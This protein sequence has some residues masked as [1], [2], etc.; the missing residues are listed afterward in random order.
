MAGNPQ[1]AARRAAHAAEQA[2]AAAARA[3]SLAA[4]AGNVEPL[5]VVQ[6]G[7]NAPA[8]PHAAEAR[9]PPPTQRYG[10]EGAP[11]RTHF[12]RRE[13]D[14]YAELT[15]Q[16]SPGIT[17]RIL[18]TRPSWCA[19]WIEDLELDS[20][21]ITELFEHLRAEH[22]GQVY[23]VQVI[24]R[25]NRILYKARVP[26]AGP[27]RRDGRKITREQWD[28]TDDAAAASSQQR[29]TGPRETNGASP[30]AIDPM[31]LVRMFLEMQATSSG[32]ITEAIREM[33][34]M[35]TKQT[36]GLVAAVMTQ[37]SQEAGSRTLG[38]QL[39]EVAAVAAQVDD[40]RAHFVASAPQQAAQPEAVDPIRAATVEIF[41]TAIQ[42]EMGRGKRQQTPQG[43]QPRPQRPQ[44]QAQP[45][46]QQAAQ[47]RPT[48][49]AAPRRAPNVEPL[50]PQK[51]SV[52]A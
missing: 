18:R 43:A 14:D 50:N 8:R 22:G 15:A 34:R 25:D 21:D 30:S 1:K 19:G 49:G 9:Q 41:K 6:P 7:P 33:Q 37:R 26:I 4:Q 42:N 13:A 17:C 16:L 36:E 48:N 23:S 46:P 11:A 52:T 51:P 45:T 31:S 32:Q 44:G 29:Q 28:G 20:G 3:A 38:S 2:S 5:H 40:I 35:Q 39:A 12:E 27:V 10:S 24:G 47:P